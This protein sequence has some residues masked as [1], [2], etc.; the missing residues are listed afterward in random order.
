MARI[1]EKY[2]FDVSHCM[3]I[4]GEARILVNSHKVDKEYKLR[5]IIS[6]TLVYLHA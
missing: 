3:Y 4:K 6:K 2:K 1:L 5:D